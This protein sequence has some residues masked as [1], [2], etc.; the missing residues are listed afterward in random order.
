MVRIS[1]LLFSLVVLISCTS[2]KLSDLE[3]AKS[4]WK[5]K[6]I[7]TYNITERIGCFCGGILQWELEVVDG[8]KYK[9]IYD[10]PEFDIG[11]TYEDVLAKA[12]TVDDIFDFIESIDKS[13]VDIFSVEYDEKYGFPKSIYLDPSKETYDD[14]KGYWFYDFTQPAALLN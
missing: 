6:S 12:K 3:V 11:E 13:K 1:L 4:K 8:K 5:A 9:V 14:E 2:D 10:E 7:S